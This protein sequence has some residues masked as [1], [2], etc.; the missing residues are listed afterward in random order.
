LLLVPSALGT[1]VRSERELTIRVRVV[2]RNGK[3]L[4]TRSELIGTTASGS[5]L[6]EEAFFAKYWEKFDAKDV[7]ACRAVIANLEKSDVPG[8]TKEVTKSGRAYFVLEDT[9]YGRVQVLWVAHV[10]PAVRD[11][12]D[13]KGT[14]KILKDTRA[15]KA[16][17]DFQETLLRIPRATKGGDVHKRVYVPV[18]SLVPN[19]AE[20]LI[21]ALTFLA[22]SLRNPE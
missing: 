21:Q 14:K 7:A 12:P 2:D 22:A 19:G 10:M 11:T 15:R 5:Q 3:E 4:D 17:N 18:R 16:W 1:V 8:L 13:N 20:P 6:N 9:P